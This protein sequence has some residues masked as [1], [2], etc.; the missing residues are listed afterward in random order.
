MDYETDTKNA[1][2]NKEK[3]KDYQDQYIKGTKWARFTMW[4]QKALIKR[5]L[6]RCNLTAKDRILDIPCGTGFIGHILSD[7]PASV[8]ASDISIDMM[9]L[10][11][12][13]Y[14]G[15]NF[16]GFVQSDITETPFKR[17]AFSCVILL[18]LMH[19][20]PKEIRGK[21]LKEV[22]QLSNKYIIVSYSIESPAQKIKQWVL[23]KVQPSHVPAPSSIPL[24]EVINEL[25]SY[26]LI[27]RNMFHIVYFLSA[28]VV[29]LVERDENNK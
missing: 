15:A 18:A 19:R 22:T 13:E 20:L 26:G 3:A 1:Y 7:N 6:Y 25:T 16:Y 4:R 9:S 24:Q 8:I 21:V 28:K 14:Q 11:N 2:R 12:N 23:K 10:A 27:V 5:A 29:F 17:S